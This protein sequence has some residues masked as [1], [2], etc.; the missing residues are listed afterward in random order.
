[1]WAVI[2]ALSLLQ[3]RHATGQGGIVSVSLLET[4][5]TWAGSKIDALM[6][7]G[8]APPRHRTGH[9]DFAPY[10]AF[11]AADGRF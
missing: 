9:P 6:N 1:M 4:G 8:E 11:D 2:G 7:Q 3:R 5:L 10:E